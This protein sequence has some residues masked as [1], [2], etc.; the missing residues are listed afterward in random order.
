MGKKAK[1]TK[2]QNAAPPPAPP[3]GPPVPWKPLLHFLIVSPLAFVVLYAAI[4]HPFSGAAP[5]AMASLVAGGLELLGYPARSEGAYVAGG[6]FRMEVIQRCVGLDL[7]CFYLAGIA[8]FRGATWRER[9]RG[10]L[11]GAPLI[12]LLSYFRLVFLFM[13]GYHAREVFD[14]VHAHGAQTLVVLVVAGLWLHW[15]ATLGRRA[16]GGHR[17]LP[18]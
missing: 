16:G 10:V 7:I 11:T 4:G 14:A 6:P 3:A 18:A 9:L 15:L 8:G 13:T 5:R 12:A 2:A 17:P 1:K